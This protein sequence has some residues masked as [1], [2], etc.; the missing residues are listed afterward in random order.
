MD[1]ATEQALI[2]RARQGSLDAFDQLMRRYQDGLYRFVRLRGAG[3]ADAEDI[4]QNS[5]LAAWRHLPGY[6]SRW[7]F[8]TWLYTIARRQASS[9]GP[10]WSELSHDLVDP[11]CGPDET[12]QSRQEQDNLWLLAH[13]LLPSDACAALWLYY[14]EARP[15]REIARILGRSTAWVKVSLHRSRKRLSEQLSAEDWLIEEVTSK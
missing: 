5:F 11:S 15:T 8:S 2:E 7:R 12:A 14:G 9:S 10:A 4:V 3:R 13:K 1:P 6:R